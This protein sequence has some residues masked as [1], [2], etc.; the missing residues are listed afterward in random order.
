[1]LDSYHLQGEQALAR[2][3]RLVKALLSSRQLPATGWDE[4]TIEMLV[5]VSCVHLSFL[6]VG[7]RKG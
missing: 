5:R 1:M 6:P 2:R 3:Q 7:K 4:A